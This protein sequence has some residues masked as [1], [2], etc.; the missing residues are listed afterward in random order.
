MIVVQY[1]VIYRKRVPLCFTDI[2]NT[3]S[4][5]LSIY[6]IYRMNSLIMLFSNVVLKY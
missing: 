6:I 5:A 4:L 1:C 3:Q 2:T